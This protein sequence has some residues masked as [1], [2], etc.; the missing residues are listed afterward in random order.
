MGIKLYHSIEGFEYGKMVVMLGLVEWS[1]QD[2]W[3]RN[4][5][6]WQP[7]PLHKV[8]NGSEK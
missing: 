2:P 7:F 8:S 3:R 1:R 4:N 6:N 5:Y